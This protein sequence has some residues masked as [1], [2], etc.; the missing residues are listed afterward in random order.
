MDLVVL[1]SGELPVDVGAW[2]DD[3]RFQWDERAGIMEH[4]GALSRADAERE[5]EKV[6]RLEFAGRDAR[7]PPQ[8][9]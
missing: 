2:P 8:R 1:R 3:W 4:S 7:G 5:A 6:V 9:L